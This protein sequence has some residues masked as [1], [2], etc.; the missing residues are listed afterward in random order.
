MAH[1]AK[2]VNNR[3]T[4]VIVAEQEFIDSL[5]QVDGTVWVQTSYNTAANSHPEDQPLRKNFAGV[6]F[7]YDPLLDAF[8]PPQ[9][10][11]PPPPQGEWVLDETAGLWK[12][13]NTAPSGAVWAFDHLNLC[14]Y[15]P[16]G[17]DAGTVFQGGARI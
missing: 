7:T 5:P 9:P 10:Q 8:I 16:E 3:V 17:A 4:E 15:D 2:V 11:V 1:Y 6:G 14:W 13:S 12:P